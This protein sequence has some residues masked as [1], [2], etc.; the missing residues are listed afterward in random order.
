MSVLLIE[1]DDHKREKIQNV[2]SMIFP[3]IEVDVAS[4]FNG[5]LKKIIA[6]KE[7]YGLILLDMSMPNFDVSPSEP[8]GGTPESFA[9]KELLTQMKL[10]GLSIP[11]LVITQF[12]TFGDANKR[13]SLRELHSQL[14]R[15]F[16]PMYK[17]SIYYNSA[18]EDWKVQLVEKIKGI[19]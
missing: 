3:S 12:D 4:S 6:G 2:I 18:Q 8:S 9:G 11:T 17:G 19:I 14:E 15:D 16:S 13:L 5:G 10:R 7:K 1:D